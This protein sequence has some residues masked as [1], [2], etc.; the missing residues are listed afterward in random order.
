M[1]WNEHTEVGQTP[2]WFYWL[3]KDHPAPQQPLLFA[4]TPAAQTHPFQAEMH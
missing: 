3:H 2:V 4:Q 1:N